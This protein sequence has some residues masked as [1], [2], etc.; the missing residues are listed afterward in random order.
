MAETGI[1]MTI[2]FILVSVDIMGNSLVCAII[3]KNRNLRY[4][5]ELQAVEPLL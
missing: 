4:V 5:R 3:W 2:L 1:V